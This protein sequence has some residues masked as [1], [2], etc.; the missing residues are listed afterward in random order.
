MA[1]AIP[2][3]MRAMI[4]T[5]HGGFEKL[6][7]H[8]DFPAPSPQSDEALIRVAACGL[9]NTD[10]NTRIAWYAQD[11]S[12]KGA[13]GGKAISF[14]RIQGADAVGK[15]VALGE[16]APTNLLGKRVLIDTWLRDW[17]DPHNAEKCR[18]FGSECN[19]GFADYTAVDAR[20]IHPIESELSDAEL[21]TFATSSITA[22]NMLSRAQVKKDE[23][24]LIT[25][26][27][28]GVGTALIQLANRRRAFAVGIASAEK[29]QAMKNLGCKAV[30]PRNAKD[31][32]AALHRAIGRENVDAVADV[33]GGEIWPQLIRSLKR[34]GRYVCSGAIAGANVQFDLRDFYLNDLSLIGATIPPPGLFGELVGYISRGEIKPLL[35]ASYPLREL[36]KAQKEFIAKRHI[37]NIVVTM[38]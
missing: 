26:A 2:K 13:W 4:L 28:G 20:Q 37:G 21:A 16:N 8:P 25:G 29:S 33:V 9:N 27:S 35:A 10:I 15:V 24:V 36:I 19:G 30:L 5:G 23:V 17:S 3:T 11:D 34:G 7:Y 38:D 6:E 32:S 22:E 14:P 18:Y 31:L 12:A 1:S